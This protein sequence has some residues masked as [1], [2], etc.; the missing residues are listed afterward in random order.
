MNGNQ[1]SPLAS[2]VCGVSVTIAP[3]NNID[4]S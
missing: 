3:L 1:L 2:P 4:S